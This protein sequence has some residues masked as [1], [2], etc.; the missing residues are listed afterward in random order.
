MPRLDFDVRV[1]QAVEDAR[2]NMGLALL[3]KPLQ[4]P[5]TDRGYVHSL[6]EA[7]LA[8][9]DV[10]AVALRAIA[11]L[12]TNAEAD[13]LSVLEEA[14]S[15]HAV[16]VSKLV[17]RVNA[18][19]QAGRARRRAPVASTRLAIQVARDLAGELGDRGLL[20]QGELGRRVIG[21][22]FGA[23]GHD[24]EHGGF[25]G[26]PDGLLEF[27]M[28]EGGDA[29]VESGK[30]SICEPP[31]SVRA[32][33]S[34]SLGAREWRHAVEGCVL[35]Y[36]HR[37]AID[38]AVFRRAVRRSGGTVLVDASGSMRLRRHELSRIV[39]AAGAILVGIYAGDGTAGELRIVARNGRRA[40]DEALDPPGSGNIVDLPCLEW[41]AA[42]RP[43]RIWVSDGRVTGIGDRGCAV[44]R[45]DSKEL[46]KR[47][48]IERVR[49]LAEAEKRLRR[50]R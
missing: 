33:S 15:P 17:R 6:A 7:D 24:D 48:R 1:F 35:R 32:R 43:P 5:E 44:L 39:D 34:R 21:C 25:P 12:G 46:C 41:L 14:G 10:G 31:L 49:N 38:G 4:L 3:G 9:G 2:I 40:A 23:C 20:P 42:Q 16:L 37:A 29:P 45:R 36:P 47:A 50:G 27:E 30:L 28:D 8:R 18:R 22:I 19:L 13:V 26:V 11:G